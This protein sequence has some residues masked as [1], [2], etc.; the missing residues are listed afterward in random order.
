MAPAGEKG[1]YKA[2]TNTIT[3]IIMVCAGGLGAV[4]QAVGVELFL[5]GLGVVML[6]G[7]V[8]SWRLPR[9]R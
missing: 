5:A 3:G 2:L 9:P 1:T 4:A 6:S 7:T 8:L